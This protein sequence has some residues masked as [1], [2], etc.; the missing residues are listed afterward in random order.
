MTTGDQLRGANYL[1]EQPLLILH[2]AADGVSALVTDVRDT[3]RVTWAPAAG[4]ACSCPAIT[5]A[6]GHVSAVRALI[7]LEHTTGQAGQ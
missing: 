6:C 5:A 2:A 7:V 1:P 3:W 4:W